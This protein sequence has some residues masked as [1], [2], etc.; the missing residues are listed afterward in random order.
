M[1]KILLGIGLWACC[2]G[3][4]MYSCSDR[5]QWLHE[6]EVLGP[7]QVRVV[8]MPPETRSLGFATEVLP[9]RPD[10]THAE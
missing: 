6:G 1:R 7:V 5:P 3:L 9:A 4:S 2:V 10:R 8:I